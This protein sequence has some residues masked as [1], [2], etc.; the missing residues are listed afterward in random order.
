MEEPQ[1]NINAVRVLLGEMV[2]LC[3]PGEGRAA[4]YDLLERNIDV[5]LKELCRLWDELNNLP[6]LAADKPL[7]AVKE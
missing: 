3:G 7:K 1:A 2:D 6:S 4:I 5:E